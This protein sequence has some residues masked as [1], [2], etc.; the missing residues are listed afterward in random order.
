MAASDTQTATQT[1]QIAA[2]DLGSNSFHLLL[3]VPLGRHFR[4]VER[5]K[6]M[7]FNVEGKILI[8]K[9]TL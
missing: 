2:L 8:G 1:R 9:I 5:L 4:T 6:E 3:V 7:T